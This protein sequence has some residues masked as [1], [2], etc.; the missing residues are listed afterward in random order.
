MGHIQLLPGCVNKVL[1]ARDAVL[2]ICVLVVSGWSCPNALELSGWDRE[3][4]IGNLKY[5]FPALFRGVCQLC[6][7]SS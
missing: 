3:H 2:P 5:V 1:L 6:S 4:M 7:G